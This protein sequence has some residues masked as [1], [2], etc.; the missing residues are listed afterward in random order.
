MDDI[1]FDRH[2][3]RELV[4]HIA[5]A[6]ETDP[7]FGATKLNSLLY[8]SD[9][10]AFGIL[11]R[12]IT[13]ATYRKLD[14]G[15]VP[16]E[17]LSVL[18]ELEREGEVTRIQRRYL[19]LTQKRVLPLRSPDL[20]AFSGAEIAIVDSVIH[21]L[22]AGN[23]AQAPALSHIEVGWQIAG[24]GE[25]IPYHSVYLSDR[26]PTTREQALWEQVRGERRS[27]RAAT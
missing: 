11:G 27:E 10:E 18:S 13:G 15:P 3:L 16:I 19:H 22:R 8:F 6:S 5:E 17:L 14:R 7:R 12:P 4:L 2:K 26:H 21:E 1:R 9:F 20:S 23:A 25:V 24:D